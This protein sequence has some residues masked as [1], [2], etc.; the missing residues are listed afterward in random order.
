MRLRRLNLK[1]FGP[2]TDRTLVFDSPLPGLHIIF[3]PNEAGKS[4]SLR[5]LKA[6]L[7]G[8]HPQT[9]DNFLHSYDQLLVGGCLENSAGDRIVFQR[10]KKRIGD[11]LDE[12]GNPMDPG[13]LAA[14]LHGVEPEIFESLYGI[15][16]DRLVRGGLDILAQKGEVG[17]ALFAAG[18][19]ISSL[20]EVIDELEQEAS[21]LFKPAGQLP[22]INRAVKRFREL[23][24]AARAASLSAGE[25]QEHQQTLKDAEAARTVL[26][27]ERDCKNRELRRLD[28]LRQAIP[29]LASL[30][31]WRNQLR[32]LG[33]VPS[34]PPDF[35]ERHR[36]VDLE[37]RELRA[38]QRTDAGRLNRIEAKLREIMPNRDLLA[39]AEVV[40]NFHQ[41]LGAYR[42]GLKDRPERE[43]MRIS[44]RKEAARL[45]QLVRPDLSLQ[46][47]ES[48]RPLLG[49]KRTIQALSSRF[50][51]IRQ[52]LD[53]ALKRS[54]DAEQELQEIE[55]RLAAMSRPPDDRGL[56]QSVRLAHQAGDI[57]IRLAGTRREV[58]SGRKKCR[59]EL[60]RLGRWSGTPD[61]L[62]KAPLPLAA[63][64]QEF[65]KKFT[66]IGENRR[67][68]EKERN[69][70]QQE[71][72][73][74]ETEIKK[75]QYA[76]EVP[77]EKELFAARKKRDQGWDLLRRRWLE[78]EDVD[79][80]SRAYDPG[81]PLPQAYEAFVE[82]VDL[83]ADRLRR[84]AERVTHVAAHRARMEAMRELLAAIDRRRN[85]LDQRENR[86]AEAWARVWEPAGIDPL[87]P[88]EMSGWL[89]E[90][91]QLRY[92]MEEILKKETEIK[93][94]ERLQRE[95]AQK[96]TT[97]LRA[98][99]ETKV[100]ADGSLGPLLVLA[101][102]VLEK[103]AEQ[104]L[105]LEREQER[106][107]KARTT[108]KQAHGEIETAR[109]ALAHWQGQ[110]TAVLAGLHRTVEITPP[111]AVD[112]IEILQDLFSRLKEADD[113]H[114]RIAGIDRD[115]EELERELGTFLEKLVPD[116]PPLPLDQAILQLRTMLDQA[117]KD[118]A[119]QDKLAEEHET[120]QAEISATG[121]LLRGA[122]EQ[123]ADLLRTAQCTKPEELPAVIARY[124]DYQRLREKISESEAT[125][126]KIGGGTGIA[127]LERQAAEIDAD[128]LPERIE[129]LRQ[130]IE[131][132][133]H[134]A[135]NRLSQTI[136]GE[137]TILAAM[138]GGDAAAVAAEK[139]EEELTRLRRLAGR[140]ARVR[141]AARILQQEIDRYRE[142]HQD[143]VLKIA[144]GYF[145]RLTLQSFTD[146]RTDVDDHGRPVLVGI[147]PGGTRLQVEAMSSGTRDQL[148]LALRLATLEWRLQSSEP[149]PFIIDDILINF[150][151]ERSKATIGA[152]SDLAVK[153][154]VILFTHHRRI[155]DDA[156]EL[157][158]N[159]PVFIHEL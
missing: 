137:E 26:E 33:H 74:A 146:L 114:K 39:Q 112:H 128:E 157:R 116:L 4:S 10:R 109:E 49:R 1:A 24:K 14:F 149:L 152:L 30:R 142:E 97:E 61:D 22:E 41:R 129:S 48:L 2:F 20:R 102:A 44:L 21:G 68:L 143:P 18:A 29:E 135:I 40:D 119:V 27:Q 85:D 111:E 51:G 59:V 65:D 38:R 80:D 145:A 117:R 140:Y 83:L 91:D 76:G 72:M 67:D 115:A 46:E 6:L 158:A 126:A 147:R 8:F 5:A 151:D 87:S 3:G 25:W 101:E 96:I 92:R 124:T 120:L 57:D 45:L 78:G 138:N 77:S 90:V 17:Q 35:L 75:I 7:F 108:L 107:N 16:H 118:A 60:Q 55:K 156:R 86:L 56:F 125:L 113:L 148:Y 131:E 106:K 36:Q 9:P 28:R 84:E 54:R 70:A 130:E 23:Q 73:G 52:Q 134:P 43:G 11:L 133:I 58:A 31:S 79:Q 150:D 15:D 81:R 121:L 100:P 50:E 32:A 98:A 155:V 69:N 136:G 122:E 13:G 94:E 47:V 110:W 89:A 19:G 53:Q 141:L 62:P 104:K 154:Q 105:A 37:I 139:M 82:Q 159:Q 99:G 42:K 63:T 127:E 88:R 34:L 95:L 64:V 123:M 153:N 144:S 71:L 12:Q 93:E 132:R 66:G 103:I